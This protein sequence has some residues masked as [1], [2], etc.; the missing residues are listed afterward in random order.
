MPKYININTAV[1]T[2]E[3]RFDVEIS[4]PSTGKKVELIGHNITDF[5]LESNIFG[6]KQGG[7]IIL[8]DEYVMQLGLDDVP[9][10]KPLNIKL[11]LDQRTLQETFIT[12]DITSS[13]TDLGSHD[14]ITK[15]D[16]VNKSSILINQSFLRC[17]IDKDTPVA[18]F[19]RDK[20]ES[21]GLKISPQNWI[22]GDMKFSEPHFFL[23]KL[24]DIVNEIKAI[25]SKRETGNLFM[26]YCDFDG[27]MC[28]TEISDRLRKASSD[29]RN[30]DLL[31]YGG[32]MG[33]GGLL[34]PKI[35]AAWQFSSTDVEAMIENTKGFK[36]Y[37]YQRHKKLMTPTPSKDGIMAPEVLADIPLI[38]STRLVT[39]SALTRGMDEYMIPGAGSD[40]KRD[41]YKKLSK[42]SLS[43][44]I[45]LNDWFN[46][47]VFN[48][49]LG[50]I[51]PDVRLNENIGVMVNNAN[52]EKYNKALCGNWLL[53]GI[54]HT[55]TQTQAMTDLYL[56]RNSIS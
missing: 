29:K 50:L 7:Y 53:A 41:D 43:R 52:S 14:A 17:K 40:D 35:P 33:S 21:I 12:T 45:T 10:V 56:I 55:Y 38:N 54:K 20:F 4:D 23:G 39:P 36:G 24:S 31:T 22:S 42:H 6:Y 44:N 25:D 48:A 47:N 11:T 18:D 49:R 32:S 46:N 19:L 16:F 2:S 26:C 27:N 13:K 51:N 1:G 5:E 28:Y 9:K 34:T 37:H 3:I 30:I 15:F 8:K